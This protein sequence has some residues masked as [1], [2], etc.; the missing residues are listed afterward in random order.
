MYV[1]IVHWEIQHCSTRGRKERKESKYIKNFPV[2]IYCLFRRGCGAKQLSQCKVGIM[3]NKIHKQ[4]L[5]N[6]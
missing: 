4:T 1:L 2:S 5:I 3:R 6:R